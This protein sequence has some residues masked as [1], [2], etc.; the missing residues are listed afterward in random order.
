MTNAREFAELVWGCSLE[1]PT[2]LTIW[3][4][5][6]GDFANVAQVIVDAGA[7]LDQADRVLFCSG[8]VGWER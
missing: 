8:M 6:F 3:E 7:A 2:G 4:A 5:Q 1:R